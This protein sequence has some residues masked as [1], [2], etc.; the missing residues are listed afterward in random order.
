MN[1]IKNNK[2]KFGIII[3]ITIYILFLRITHIGCPIRWFT[4]VPCPGCGLTRSCLAYLNLDFKAAFEYHAL[5]P[6]VI[7]SF[8]YIFFGKRPL[9]KSYKNEKIFFAL[10]VSITL[11]YYIIRLFFIKNDII[12]IDFSRSFMVK[13]YKTVKKLFS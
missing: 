8:A 1:F 11:I 2:S 5:T 7:P 4:G 9:F 10:L 3:T 12:Y 6:I 13:L